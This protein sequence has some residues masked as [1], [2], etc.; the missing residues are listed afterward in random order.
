MNLQPAFV[1]AILSLPE[2]QDTPKVV[3]GG[4][5][6]KGRRPQQ[7][8]VLLL[9]VDKASLPS[10][11]QGDAQFSEGEGRGVSMVGVFD[12]HGGR[13]CS[14]FAA[15]HIPT[16]FYAA[17]AEITAKKIT[18]GD[19]S[20][21]ALTHAL[22]ASYRMTHDDFARM[23]RGE[24]ESS[25]PKTRQRLHDAIER[26]KTWSS[27]S[28]SNDRPTVLNHMHRSFPSNSLDNSFESVRNKMLQQRLSLGNRVW[29]DGSTAICCLVQGNRVIVANL[30]DSRA[31]GYVGGKVTPLTIDHKPNLPSERDRIQSAG[32]V[33]TCMMGCHRVMGMLAMS[34]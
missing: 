28:T 18:S 9:H 29:D 10:L 31:V 34:R 5:S 17:L 7:E 1:Q 2:N 14:R 11:V 8:D 33:V 15:Q 22:R 21:E 30:G 3:C 12:G 19:D 32:G 13:R 27:M 6:I 16:N 20:R 25:R 4:C 24:S 26:A 23:A